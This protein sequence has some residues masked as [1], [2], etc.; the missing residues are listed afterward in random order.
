ML[1]ACAPGGRGGACAGG[2]AARR[3]TGHGGGGGG[4]ILGKKRGAL[5]SDPVFMM[6]ALKAPG[7][8]NAVRSGSSFHQQWQKNLHNNIAFAFKNGVSGVAATGSRS[9]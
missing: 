3:A 4:G 8:I 5:R 9:G 1:R 7:M 2:G 6:A